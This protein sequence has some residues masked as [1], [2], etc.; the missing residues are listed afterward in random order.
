MPAFVIPTLRLVLTAG[1]LL[2]SAGLAAAACGPETTLAPTD[3]YS[4]SFKVCDSRFVG[5]A[6]ARGT[7]WVAVGFSTDQYMPGTDVFMAGVLPDGSTYGSDRFAYFRS[8][9]VL[10]VRQDARLLAA[11]EAGGFTT[12]TF[13]RPLSTG[14][15][16]D[17]DLTQG[18][19]Y[20]MMA[21]NANSDVLTDRHTHAD[22]SDLAYAFAPMPVPEPQTLALLLAGLGV[23][24]A[25]ARRMTAAR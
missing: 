23:V 12:I 22:P 5:T 19:Y 1:L 14:D 8:A 3:D 7:G 15:A 24:A 2:G 25:R 21:F 10:D 13:D 18:S 11:S 9:P 20:L 6:R 4:L 17:Y 16:M